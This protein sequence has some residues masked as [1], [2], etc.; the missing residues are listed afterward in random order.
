MENTKELFNPQKE[1]HDAYDKF[2]RYTHAILHFN[3]VVWTIFIITGS[4]TLFLVLF[5]GI[6]IFKN[7][8]SLLFLIYPLFLMLIS[9]AYDRVKESNPTAEEL[10]NIQKTKAE[11]AKK[12]KEQIEQNRVIINLLIEERIITEEDL[13]KLRYISF[14]NTHMIFALEEFRR[15]EVSIHTIVRLLANTLLRTNK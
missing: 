8:Y 13:E 6:T 2:I 15:I 1:V 4:A 10:V 5:V 14:G 3:E 11:E 12:T 9:D 7:P